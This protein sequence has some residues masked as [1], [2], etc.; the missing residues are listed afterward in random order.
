MEKARGGYDFL[1]SAK[2]I[3][4]LHLSQ[5]DRKSRSKF[6]TI[7]DTPQSQRVL[8]T[9]TPFSITYGSDIQQISGGCVNRL[10][11]P[12]FLE[13]NQKQKYCRAKI[14]FYALFQ[15][16]YNF[17]FHIKPLIVLLLFVYSIRYRSRFEFAYGYLI[18][19]VPFAEK[20]DSL[21]ICLCHFEKNRFI[22]T[23]V[24]L[25]LDFISFHSSFAIT[26]LA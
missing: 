24:C 12:L 9:E 25:F 22:H 1:H 21:L 17:R 18:F 23:C 20:N 6:G 8:L 10:I 26:T 15:K 2:S 16:L 4:R 7:L 11:S 3:A 5:L 13:R 19:P 14:F